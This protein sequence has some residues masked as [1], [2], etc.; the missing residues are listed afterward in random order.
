L[1][2]FG[3]LEMW[4]MAIPVRSSVNVNGRV[5]PGT[6]AVSISSTSSVTVDASTFNNLNVTATANTTLN[7]LNG[8]DHQTIRLRFIQAGSGN[9]TL[10]VSN[11]SFGSIITTLGDCVQMTGLYTYVSLVFNST[12]STWDV[13]AVNPGFTN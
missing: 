4:T 12:T 9:Y 8:V 2:W 3:H 1:E 6:S 5:Q 7:I 10:S 13:A 11:G